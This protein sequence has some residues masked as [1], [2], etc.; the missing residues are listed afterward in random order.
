VYH[1]MKTF[2]DAVAS[3][4]KADL[5]SK[6]PTRVK[7]SVASSKRSVR[8]TNKGS[9]AKASPGNVTGFFDNLADSKLR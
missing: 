5:R 7:K 4:R 2:N 1:A 8:K 3:Q 9:G 6:K